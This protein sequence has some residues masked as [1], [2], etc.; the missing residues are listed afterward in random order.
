MLYPLSY[1][2]GE[3]SEFPSKNGRGGSV[4]SVGK[5][6][7]LIP[8]SARAVERPGTRLEAR[9]VVSVAAES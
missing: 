8:R 4:D 5:G 2:G 6:T 3:R 1:G 9:P 7:R